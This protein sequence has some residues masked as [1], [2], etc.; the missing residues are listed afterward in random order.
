[1]GTLCHFDEWVGLDRLVRT[2]PILHQHWEGVTFVLE[3]SLSNHHLVYLVA[4]GCEDLI[5]QRVSTP[6]WTGVHG[7]LV[8]PPH[9]VEELQLELFD[10]PI[11]FLLKVFLVCL[12][13][14]QVFRNGLFRSGRV[15]P[16]VL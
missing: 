3:E 1:M 5:K 11:T 15:E 16:I 9:L 12:H 10:V 4:L 6:R 7:N 14:V 8:S 2:V 13:V